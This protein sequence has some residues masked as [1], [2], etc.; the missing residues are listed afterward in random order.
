MPS[1]R[2][3]L[4][5]YGGGHVTMMIPV[6]RALAARG[7]QVTVLGLTTAAPVLTRAGIAHLGFHDLVEAGDAAALDHGRRLADELTGTVVDQDES[8]AYL[9]LSYADLIER[10]GA[11][12]AA[13]R[14]ADQRR[15]AFLPLGPLRRLID[16]L[17]PHL[18]VA[19]SSPRAEMAA[20]HIARERG[21]PSICLWDLF[22]LGPE[23]WCDEPGY[24]SRVC[25]LSPPVRDTLIARGRPADEIVVT[26]NPAF[27]RLADHTLTMAGTRLRSAR[28]WARRRVLLWASGAEPTDASMPRR[29]EAALFALVARRDDWQLVVRLHPSEHVHFGVL[30][31]RIALSPRDEDLATLLAACDAVVTI[32]STVGLEGLLLGKALVQ[33]EMSP[34]ARDIPY[35]AMGLACGTPDL[36]GLEAAIDRALTA[37]PDLRDLLPAPGSAAERIADLGDALVSTNA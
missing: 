30:P 33:V 22:A 8:V 36:A 13:K 28:G 11:A 4:V 9:G 32:S 24:G 18:V 20:L 14:Y 23:R 34:F 2:V 31:A 16:R 17:Y 6:Q 3:L 26:G 10:V 1:R 27:D 15:A 12:T 21:I 37:P 29:I 7:W 19:T 25:V 35:R 5:C